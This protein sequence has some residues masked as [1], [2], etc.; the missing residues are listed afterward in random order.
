MDGF[1][2]PNSNNLNRPIDNGTMQ[3]RPQPQPVTATTEPRPAPTVPAQTPTQEVPLSPKPKR[4]MGKIIGIV[5]ASLVLV[6]AVAAAL[7][8]NWYQSQLQPVNSG[9]TS[10]QKVQINKGATLGFVAD[11]LEKRGIIR[12]STAFQIYAQLAGKAGAIKEGTCIVH[13]NQTPEQIINILAKGC[14]EFK[15]ITFFPG[16]TIEKPLYKP[17]HAQ[18]DQTMY[19]KHVLAK[20]GYSDEDIAK[21]LAGNYS[22]PLFQGRP[23]GTTLEG[24]VFGETYYVEPNASAEKVL[25]TAFDEMYKQIAAEGLPDKFKA[26]NLNMYQAITLASIV[27]R[28]LNC[29]GK[30][31]PERKDRCYQYQRTIAQIFLKRLQEG[32]VLG[33]DVTF[34][35]AADMKG[36]FPTVNIDSPYNTRIHKG[37]PPGPIAT[38]GL[39][40]LKAVGNPT[41]TDYHFFIA[42]DDG[43]I[44][45]AKTVAEHE[46]NI[47]NHCQILC[48]E[49]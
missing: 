34:I 7:G 17:D 37:L 29:E 9:D 6:A 43:L 12:S 35:Y 23:T 40:A 19:V 2:R 4:K 46:A 3:S 11:S 8:W 38:P 24:Y 20:A 32:D 31:T 13:K 10:D 5:G 36:V 16:G 18:L 47:K 26:Q 30:P 42:G 14:N 39:L 21:A 48:N 1:K 49:L 44:Y 41:P 28:E 15:S 25:Q 22:G 27:Q 45:F 33:S